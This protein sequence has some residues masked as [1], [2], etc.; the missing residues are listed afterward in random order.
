[1]ET[2]KAEPG[3]ICSKH[4]VARKVTIQYAS[5]TSEIP[6]TQLHTR[7]HTPKKK[8]AAAAETGRQNKRIHTPEE[9][10]LGMD[11]QAFLHDL[12]HVVHVAIESA[13]REKKHFHVT[14]TAKM[15]VLEQGFLDG[16]QRNTTVHG[17]RLKQVQERQRR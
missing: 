9:D 10:Q 8:E 2:S 12:A 3:L 4:K 11:S 1:M 6:M 16:S 13:I 14:E 17:K 5:R 7:A 15:L